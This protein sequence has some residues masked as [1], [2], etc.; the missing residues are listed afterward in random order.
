MTRKLSQELPGKELKDWI[1]AVLHLSADLKSD[2]EID[3]IQWLEWKINLDSTGPGE[4]VN[5]QHFSHH[6]QLLRTLIPGPGFRDNTLLNQIAPSST[7]EGKS[8]VCLSVCMSACLLHPSLCL[9]LSFTPTLCLVATVLGQL[10]Y[11]EHREKWREQHVPANSHVSRLPAS[12]LSHPPYS[13]PLSF[14]SFLVTTSSVR[15]PF[16]SYIALRLWLN[17]PWLP[18]QTCNDEWIFQVR[19]S[20]LHGVHV[21]SLSLCGGYVGVARCEMENLKCGC[22]TLKILVR[23]RGGWRNRK[24]KT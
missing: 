8:A 18:A 3:N 19:G 1:T 17:L 20:L 12:L 15:L 13:F 10:V 2:G 23:V 5:Q 11:F 7:S 22:I 16:P 4:F 9:Y 21:I 14:P 6:V 24:K